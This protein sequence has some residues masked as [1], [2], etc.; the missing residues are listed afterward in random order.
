DALDGS[1]GGVK[2]PLVG[3]KLANV[4]TAIGDFRTNFINPLQQAIDDFANPTQAFQ[5]SA[6]GAQG[7]AGSDPISKILFKLLG[8]AGLNVLER[9]DCNSLLAPTAADL[10]Y[11]G[12]AQQS[13]ISLDQIFV[14]WHFKLGGTIVS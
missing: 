2:L 11:D 7:A 3:D 4:A 8:P 14:H 13:G 5:D 10:G 1:I 12:N 9:L 6:G